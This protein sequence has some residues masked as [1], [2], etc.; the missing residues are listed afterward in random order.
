MFGK[1]DNKESIL[2]KTIGIRVSR[3]DTENVAADL[4]ITTMDVNIEN[5]SAV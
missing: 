5:I 2:I 3:P 1:V 4:G